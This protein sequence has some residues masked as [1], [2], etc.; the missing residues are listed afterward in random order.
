MPGCGLP[1]VVA[2][3]VDN[4]DSNGGILLTRVLTRKEENR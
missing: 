1:I 3:A 2:E 4:Q